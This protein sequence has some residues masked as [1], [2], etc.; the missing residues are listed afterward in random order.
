MRRVRTCLETPLDASDFM[1][2]DNRGHVPGAEEAAEKV[3]AEPK[4]VPQRL[5]PDCKGSAYGT[6]KSVPLSKTKAS[7]PGPLAQATITRA[8]GPQC[9]VYGSTD[10]ALMRRIGGAGVRPRDAIR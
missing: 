7:C 6:D 10:S 2:P 8:F 9:E 3:V 1:L 5:K 4:S